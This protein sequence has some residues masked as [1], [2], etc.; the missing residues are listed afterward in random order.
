MMEP[1]WEVW[2][3]GFAA[4][5]ESAGAQYYGTYPG[6]SFKEAVLKAVKEHGLQGSFDESRLSYW[7]CRFFSSE[8]EARASFG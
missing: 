7:G 6:S 8:A 1:E 3:E 2:M 4:T 5:G